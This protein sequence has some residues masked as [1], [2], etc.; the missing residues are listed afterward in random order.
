M[1]AVGVRNL[2]N[3]EKKRKATLV[4]A[5]HPKPSSRAHFSTMESDGEGPVWNLSALWWTHL[6]GGL[7]EMKS[8][9]SEENN[10]LLQIRGSSG[11]WKTIANLRRG[12]IMMHRCTRNRIYRWKNSLL[13]AVGT[14]AC[15]SKQN[16]LFS[17]A[18]QSD[19]VQ[20]LVSTATNISAWIFGRRGHAEGFCV[21][22]MKGQRFWSTLTCCCCSAVED[23]ET[24]A[25]ELTKPYH[26]P[27]RNSP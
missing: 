7:E 16:S 15:F 4:K 22:F 23:T 9:H 20:D 17:H 13:A 18:P 8:P 1:A 19:T 5:L 26:F 3:T 11:A 2:N 25:S 6:L 21:S 14:Q 27:L 24:D 10:I 12:R